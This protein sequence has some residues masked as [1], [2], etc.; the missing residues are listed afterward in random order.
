MNFQKLFLLCLLFVL[1]TLN[2]F[3]QRNLSQSE[4]PDPDPMKQMESFILDEG[5]EI[6]LFASDPMMAKPIGMNWDEQGRLWV[7][8]S[9]LYPHIKPGQRSDDQVIVLED[10]NGD[11]VADKSSVF[12]ENLLIP[13]GIMP[14]D[15]GVY[16]A[17]STE[18]LFMEDLDGD[19]KEDK[20]TVVLSGFG[21]EDTHHIIHSFKGAPDGM[22]YF[23]QSIY[24]HSHVE[25]PHG[26]RRLMAG[27]IWHY[28]PET[29]KLEVF[30]RGFVN[31]W[32]HIFDRYGQSFATDGAYGEGI[33][34]V[35]PGSVFFTAYNS[36]RIL[37]GLNPGQP[38]QCG[39]EIINSSHFPDSWQGN[40]ITNDF[41][42]HR[43]NRFIISDSGSGF[44]SRQAKDLIRTNHKSFRPIDVKIGPDGA[45]YIADWYNPIIQHGEVDFRDPRRDHV[46]G[47]IWRVTHKDRQLSKFPKLINAQTAS[48]VEHLRSPD[49][50]TRHFAKRQLRQRPRSEVVSEL[51]RLGGR[52]DLDA[53]DKLEIL[54]ANQAINHVN[55]GLLKVLLNSKDHRIRS[56]AVRVVYHWKDEL[57]APL[58]LVSG[59]IND[60]HPRV[61]LEAISTL[62]NIGTA[63]AFN[64]IMDA[65]D[66]E[67]DSNIDFALWLAA[68]EL[69]SVWLPLLEE[70][71]LKI[72]GRHKALQFIL[73]A[74]EEPEAL[75][76]LAGS[77]SST[78]L[79]GAGFREL[80]SLYADLGDSKDIDLLYASAFVEGREKED[81]NH[82]FN[83]LI[84]VFK[85]R[86]IQPTQKREQELLKLVRSGNE[87]GTMLSGTWKIEGVKAILIKWL[88]D[89]E[90][91]ILAVTALGE[92]GDVSSRKTLIKIIDDN[93]T[94]VETKAHAITAIARSNLL[95]SAAYA[96]E[97]MSKAKTPKPVKTILEFFLTRK[98]GPNFL[99]DAISGKK[100]NTNVAGEAVRMTIASGGETKKLIQELSK[101]GS[102]QT[103]Q[104]GLSDS[105]MSELMNLVKSEGSPQRGE[106]IYRRSQ[107]LCQSCHAIAGAGGAIG[108]DLVSLGSS[109]P[110][111]YIVD[112]LL[113]PAKKIKEGYHTT[114]VTTKQGEVITGGLVRDS[115]SE[116]VLRMV[117]GSFKN[118]KTSVIEKKEISPVSLMPP[119]LTASLRKDEFI[120]LMSFLSALGKEGEYKVPSGR[121]VRR[122]RVLPK[123]SRTSGLIKTKGIQFTLNGKNNLPWKPV[124][125][126]VDGGLPLAEMGINNGFNNILSIAKF[127]IEVSVA[128]KIGIRLKNPKGLQLLTGGEMIEAKK[129]SSF[130][131]S[132]GRQEIYVIVDTD[133]RE[134]N[135]FIEIVD[136]DGSPGVAELVTGF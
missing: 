123:D 94:N 111:D 78:D 51:K 133:V 17:N 122:W 26:V 46:H 118:I 50:V 59:A 110:I 65:F 53:E 100:M 81:R 83:E 77:L 127:E 13:T 74:S 3:S 80:S 105:E 103:V 102:L 98:D 71:K 8:S 72:K 86:S 107:L 10:K 90:K 73:K 84:R 38:K 22:M 47:R 66:K 61:R 2:L 56:A 60:D 52:D 93:E 114:V 27:G 97:L 44:V 19:L 14:G 28:R 95:Q 75:K 7:V 120:D 76:L 29:G 41:R 54:W 128:G 12:A 101:A 115:D 18:I 92:I 67:I 68:R 91:N 40:L 16:V 49:G 99:A 136:V 57:N 96:S 24:I 9:R 108:P 106:E 117:D 21:T 134:S 70:G 79:K 116:L 30:S 43:V 48:V 25:T 5:L 34:Y 131:F 6:N 109:A 58:S 69:K 39:L 35:F 45:L 64:L 37:R 36:K 85:D 33:N 89:D 125:S 11:G 112:S 121:Q 82:V 88:N 1:Q 31:S 32:G 132:Q 4:I 63:Q 119:G 42:G 55:E 15:G 130:T 135:L 87:A 23:N 62:R 126:Y 104:A 124:Y 113:E 20:R 129:N